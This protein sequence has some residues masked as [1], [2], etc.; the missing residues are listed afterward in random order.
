MSARRGRAAAGAIYATV[1]IACAEPTAPAPAEPTVA[2]PITTGEPAVGTPV[3]FA[4]AVRASTTSSP[5]DDALDRV[6]ATFPESSSAAELRRVLRLLSGALG[7]LDRSRS[8]RLLN[9]SHRALRVLQSTPASFGLE[10]EL[11]AV[12][13]A[14]DVV[15]PPLDEE[16]P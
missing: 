6:V 2:A 16:R 9:E 11:A 10:A 12:A 7:G 5:V 8:E 15:L 14:L 4:Q 13:L 3:A 1:A